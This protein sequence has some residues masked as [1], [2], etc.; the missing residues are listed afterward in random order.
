MA[1]LDVN[2][3]SNQMLALIKFDT[4]IIKVFILIFNVSLCIGKHTICYGNICVIIKSATEKEFCGKICILHTGC[5]DREVAC[6]LG[7]IGTLGRRCIP[8][9]RVCDG[10]RDCVG[11]TDE[12]NCTGPSKIF[13][14]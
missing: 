1:N 10:F 2:P 13:Y 9:S 11:G 12:M 5:E 6:P 4:H 14:C 3:G 8:E 7:R